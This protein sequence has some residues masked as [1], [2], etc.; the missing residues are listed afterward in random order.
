M[1]TFKEIS[2]ADIKTSRSALNQL[3]DIIQEDI[4]G[5]DTRREFQVFVTGGIGQGVTSSLFQTVYDQDHTLQSANAVLDMT[6][7]LYFS[8]STVQDTLISEDASG[9][10]LFPSESMMMREK[11]DI[12]KQFASTLMGDAD[13]YFTTPFGS[14]DETDRVDNA[15]FVCFKRLFARDKIKRETFAMR[16]YQ[17]ASLAGNSYRCWRE[18]DLIDRDLIPVG[19]PELELDVDSEH[20]IDPPP[21]WADGVTPNL[22]ITSTGSVAIFTD[23]GAATSKRTTFG[24]E[25]ADIVDSSDTSTKVGLLFYDAGVAVFNVNRVIDA[26]QAVMGVI[27]GMS[28]ESVT[29]IT[30]HSAW[31][32]HDSDEP[33]GN[34][35]DADDIVETPTARPYGDDTRTY[36]VNVQ[37]GQVG[38]GYGWLGHPVT[39]TLSEYSNAALDSNDDDDVNPGYM[40][41]TG[42]DYG[43]G[44]PYARFVPDFLVS[45]SI[46]NIVDHFATC[47][48]QSGSLTAITF[49]NVT[50]I[51]STLIF[52]RATADEFNYSANPTYVDEENRIV[53]IDEGQE[54]TQRSFTFPTTVGMYDANDNLLAVA[55][56][57]RPIEKNDEKDITIRVRL[58]F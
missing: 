31:L 23:I 5:S 46:D 32:S 24:G 47:R 49:Q 42:D 7:G 1:A 20:I 9:K 57:S 54:D 53:V 36:D 6:V 48:F 30:C 37:N 35:I 21:Y 3:V 19:N 44:N 56:L 11:V 16:F 33:D 41:G 52:C 58:D 27:D 50:T 38:I 40:D 15:F 13:A 29:S 39:G 34:A 4:S 55:K 18:Q 22:N 12:Y 25:V 51:N 43:S 8:G 26:D 45:G 28:A 17:S 2:A 10:L 14:D